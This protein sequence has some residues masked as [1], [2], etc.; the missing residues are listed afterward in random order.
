MLTKEEFINRTDDVDLG[1]VFNDMRRAQRERDWEFYYQNS[2]AMQAQNLNSL[3]FGYRQ[4]LLD[5]MLGQGF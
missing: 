4:S 3:G 2:R 5:A 1:R